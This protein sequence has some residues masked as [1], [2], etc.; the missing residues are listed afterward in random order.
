MDYPKEERHDFSQK[1]TDKLKALIIKNHSH[2]SYD[3]TL[4]DSQLQS[5]PKKLELIQLDVKTA[6]LYGEVD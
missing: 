4:Y 3:T 6:F 5:H 1:V 2:Q